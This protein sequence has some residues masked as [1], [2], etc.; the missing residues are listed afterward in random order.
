MA[1]TVTTREGRTS[2]KARTIL[3]AFCAVVVLS[4]LPSWVHA[5]SGEPQ[6]I[7]MQEHRQTGSADFQIKTVSTR[8]DMISGGD[9][10]IRIDS[11]RITLDRIA[12]S[13]NGKDV[14]GAFRPA[15]GTSSL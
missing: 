14:N 15:A 1:N 12:V 2:M 7:Q 11:P 9:V 5:Q 4:T 3:S 6:P 13:L 8:N 10:L